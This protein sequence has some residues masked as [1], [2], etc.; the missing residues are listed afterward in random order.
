MDEKMLPWIL[1]GGVVLVGFF[2][3]SRGNSNSGVQYMAAPQP[4]PVDTATQTHMADILAHEY[5]TFQAATAAYNNALLT[6]N[7]NTRIAEINAATTRANIQAAESAA[8]NKNVFSF[9]TT[10]VQTG[11]MDFATYYRS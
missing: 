11:G 10:L 9:L 1:G 3:Y 5:D 6:T 7:A 4:A 8:K 2:L